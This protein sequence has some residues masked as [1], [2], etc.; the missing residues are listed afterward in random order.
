MGARYCDILGYLPQNFGY[1]PIS[2]HMNFFCI[3]LH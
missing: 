1:Y 3:W 2:P